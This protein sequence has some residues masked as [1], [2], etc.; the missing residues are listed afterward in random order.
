MKFWDFPE[1]SYV[2]CRSA[3]REATRIY[4]FTTNNHASFHLRWKEH[5]LNHQKMS[6]YYNIIAKI[7]FT[8]YVF[9]N[10]LIV[11]NGHILTGIYFIFL[12]NVLDQTWKAFNTKFGPQWEDRES[13]YQ[14][15]QI[16]ALFCKLVALILG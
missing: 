14:I 3:T 10:S 2:L 11:R 15:R 5:L 13:S 7:S 16:L 1:I 9:I 6:K 8:F 12:K 4:Q